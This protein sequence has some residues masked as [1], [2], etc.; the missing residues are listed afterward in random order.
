M[1]KGDLKTKKGTGANQT[2]IL[3]IGADMTV[4]TA[5]A[6][7]TTGMKWRMPCLC[8]DEVDTTGTDDLTTNPTDDYNP[9]A[10][11]Y[12]EDTSVLILN[13]TAGTAVDLNGL[14]RQGNQKYL[15]L[16]NNSGDQIKP[17]N[18]ALTSAA[19]NRF[20][21]GTAPTIATDEAILIYYSTALSRWKVI[22]HL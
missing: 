13:N 4:L 19:A 1:T 21:L 15:I 8:G 12:D 16:I 3:P 10:S 17:Q 22:S 5:D 11:G 6:G 9:T 7:E 14:V 20:S 18:E 2:E